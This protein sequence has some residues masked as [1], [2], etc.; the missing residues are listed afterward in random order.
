MSSLVN[1]D[2]KGAFGPA[3]S[4]IYNV[5]YLNNSGISDLVALTKDNF[6]RLS[7]MSTAGDKEFYNA[8]IER[9]LM[10]CP[11]SPTEVVA[12]RFFQSMQKKESDV[13]CRKIVMEQIVPHMLKSAKGYIQTV[14]ADDLE[15]R[16]WAGGFV[17]C[18]MTEEQIQKHCEVQG[19]NSDRF[20]QER[21]K[22]GGDLYK[23]VNEKEFTEKDLDLMID[24][25][26]TALQSLKKADH[27]QRSLNLSG[28]YLVLFSMISNDPQNAGEEVLH[29]LSTIFRQ[30]MFEKKKGE[31]AIVEKKA[32]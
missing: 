8:A 26:R 10:Q 2:Q 32:L 15:L 18:L 1:F 25:T 22:I 14:D 23:A 30:K 28:R 6:E 16:R 20:M 19:D 9:N 29:L 31:A 5:P 12:T 13:V 4:L 17:E 27:Y 11:M 7:K 21:T 24:A 3:I